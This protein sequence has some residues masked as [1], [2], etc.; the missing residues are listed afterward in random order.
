MNFFPP[1][2]GIMS[3]EVLFA[4]ILSAEVLFA[5]ILSAGVSFVGILSAGILP[6]SVSLCPIPDFQ[7]PHP[8]PPAHSPR[9]F[10][11]LAFFRLDS[12]H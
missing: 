8:Q 6:M 11:L 7:P 10:C 9:G 12:V 1:P 4:R 3:T 5:G 2:V